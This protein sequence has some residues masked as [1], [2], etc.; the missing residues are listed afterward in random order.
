MHDF[1]NKIRKEALFP[2]AF[3]FLI[4]LICLVLLI[5]QGQETLELRIYYL[6]FAPNAYRLQTQFI[7]VISEYFHF[8]E[9]FYYYTTVATFFLS[10]SLIYYVLKLDSVDL[11]L[12]LI[13]LLQFVMQ[14]S[15]IENA[16][17][18]VLLVL[19]IVYKKPVLIIPNIIIKEFS[20]WQALGYYFIIKR[21]YSRPLVF[22][23]LAGALYVSIVL[24]T[25]LEQY[26]FTGISYIFSFFSTIPFF[27]NDF[28]LR[29]EHVLLVLSL[30]LAIFFSIETKQDIYLYLWQAIPIMLFG[31]F[32]EIQ[33]WFPVVLIILSNKKMERN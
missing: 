2:Y 11:Y 33:L 15:L 27:V 30:S 16:F 21:K 26:Q 13:F 19:M 5:N 6:S 4:S 32:W 25:G 20:L 22:G 24:L 31:L 8:V 28:M 18:Y 10:I 12:Y 3:I 7:L 29:E 1:A 17:S 23:S 14:P 9:Y